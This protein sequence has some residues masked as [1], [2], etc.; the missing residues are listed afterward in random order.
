MIFGSKFLIR[1]QSLLWDCFVGR[2]DLLA[3]TS[4]YHFNN[5]FISAH[6]CLSVKCL[7]LIAPPGHEATQTPQ[8]LHKTSLITAIFTFSSENP[9]C[10]P[11]TP[12]YPPLL[13]GELK[14]DSGVL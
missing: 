1:W 9:P 10:P 12:L 6:I 5:P 11:S 7:A 14:G 4:E 13:R 3:M 8:P 2:N